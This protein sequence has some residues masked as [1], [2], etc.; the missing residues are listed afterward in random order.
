MTKNTQVRTCVACKKKYHKR[1]LIRICRDKHG[2]VSVDLSGKKEG[3]GCYIYPSMEAF[4]EL[5]RKDFSQISRALKKTLSKGEILRLKD[6]LPLAIDRKRSRKM[7]GDVSS[8][9]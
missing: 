3:R 6:E 2:K 8:K 1:D 7:D 9:S 4:E 5:V